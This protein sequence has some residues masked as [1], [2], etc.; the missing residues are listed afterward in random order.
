M[1]QHTDQIIQ[2]AIDIK[3]S[4]RARVFAKKLSTAD[5][6]DR[7]RHMILKVHEIPSGLLTLNGLKAKPCHASQIQTSS[8]PKQLFALF[9]SIDLILQVLPELLGGNVFSCNEI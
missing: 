5:L 3:Y 8:R 7:R 2:H 6:M 4:Q 1:L 9:Q